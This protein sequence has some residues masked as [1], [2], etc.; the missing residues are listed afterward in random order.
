MKT[1]ISP[2]IS[3]LVIAVITTY[4]SASY[5]SQKLEIGI[6]HDAEDL[7]LIVGKNNRCLHSTLQGGFPLSYVVDNGSA[8]VVNNISFPIPGLS[9]DHFLW[10]PWLFNLSWYYL[11]GYILWLNLKKRK[12]DK[13]N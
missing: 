7:N 13:S 10:L 11:L 4:L 3:C 2:I 12:N 9:E 6:C 8:S 1:K 5:H